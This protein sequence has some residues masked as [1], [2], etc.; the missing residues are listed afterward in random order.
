[1]TVTNSTVQNP[2]GVPA[3]MVQQDPDG[4]QKIV[5]GG[6]D[7]LSLREQGYLMVDKTALLPLLAIKRYVFLSRPRRFG[8]SMLLSMLKEL[9]TNGTEK[10]KGLAVHEQGLWHEPTTPHVILIDFNELSNPNTFEKDLLCRLCSAFEKA[11]F[12][13][14]LDLQYKDNHL[15]TIYGELIKLQ[16]DKHIVVLIDEWDFPLSANLHDRDAFEANKEIL[17]GFYSWLRGLQPV[18]FIMVTGI[19]RY[20]NTAMLTGQY[21]QDISMDPTFANLLGYTEEELKNNFA[22][23]ITKTAKLLNTSEDGVLQQ[24]KLKYDGFCF[25]KKAEF[26]IYCPLSINAFFEQVY[27]NREDPPEFDSY[28]MDSANTPQGLRSYL[29]NRQLNFDKLEQIKASGEVLIQTQFT[30]QMTFESVRLVPLLIQSGFMTIKGLVDATQEGR[31]RRQLLCKFANAEVEEVYAMVLLGHIAD[32]NT[33]NDDDALID[34]E[35]LRYIFL[36]A[37][38]LRS[39]DIEK[40][41][42]CINAVLAHINYELWANEQDREVFYRVLIA[43]ILEIGL[44]PNNVRQEVPNN[45]GRSDIELIL[46]DSLV[47]FELKLA[48][49]KKRKNTKKAADAAQTALQTEPA[50]LATQIRLSK[51]AYDQV[52]K[53]GYGSGTMSYQLNHWHGVVLVV[54]AASRQ[55]CYW[56]HFDRDQ[57][58][59]HGAV[60]PIVLNNPNKL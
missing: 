34:N 41:V 13:G 35:I 52:I 20:K 59:G 28:W 3:P 11:G 18:D 6:S 27:Y 44:G 16:Q 38:A 45:N 58:L 23:Y 8:K 42:N 37:N 21:L 56:R 53:K 5:T 1:M 25:D 36:I 33:N 60:K 26:N 55:I 43:M 46:G 14:A 19:G 7:F 40:A 4:L 30:S 24:L 57:E 54:S 12:H 51:E 9:Y 10:F 39:F 49:N 47:V 22:A 15:N 2:L 48:R 17:K 29:K 50:S 32:Y 31:F